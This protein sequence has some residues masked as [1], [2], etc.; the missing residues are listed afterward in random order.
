MFVLSSC[1][2]EKI[3]APNY[4]YSLPSTAVTWT[5]TSDTTVVLG[6]AKIAQHKTV[7][8]DLSGSMSLT[9]FCLVSFGTP[10]AD[11]IAITKSATIELTSST[12]GGGQF[13]LIVP[14]WKPSQSGDA[15]MVWQVPTS[16]PWQAGLTE[17]SREAFYQTVKLKQGL[18][19][20][21]IGADSKTRIDKNF[22]TRGLATAAATIESRC[23]R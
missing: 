4:E 6:A 17:N 9:L 10:S 1:G 18:K 7:A 8:F 14:S 5:V 13:P 11:G 20:Y 23:H 15:V 3:T 21:W 12:F 16:V 19:L 2:G 22:D